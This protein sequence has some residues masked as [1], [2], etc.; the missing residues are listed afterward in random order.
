MGN[1][2]FGW[3][4]GVVNCKQILMKDITADSL[5]KFAGV[6]TS[7]KPL[8]DSNQSLVTQSGAIAVQTPAGTKYLPL[9]THP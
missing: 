3:H 9:Y 5:F 7:G 8:Y 1:S 2:K 4:S 6:L